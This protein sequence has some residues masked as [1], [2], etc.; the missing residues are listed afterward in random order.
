MNKGGYLIEK[1][2]MLKNNPKMLSYWAYKISNLF[3]ENALNGGERYDPNILNRFDINDYS[4]EARYL[5]A[6]TFISK[7]DSVLDIAC[8]TG[9][10]LLMLSEICFYSTGVD[11]SRKAIKYANEHYKLDSKINFIQSD[12]FNFNERSDVV[13]SFETI[14]HVKGEISDVL[15]KLISLTNKKL[16]VSV[17]YMEPAGYNKHHLKYNINELDFEFLNSLYRTNYFYQSKDGAIYEN[18]KND[19]ETLII[20]IDKLA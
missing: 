3:R 20:I 14:E 17:P 11:A 15:K 6:Q 5:F 18:K 16:I 8:G 19:V 12:I 1:I 2:K 9:Y 13:V 7:D 10:G 4:Q